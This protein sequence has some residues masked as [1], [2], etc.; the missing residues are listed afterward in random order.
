MEGITQFN[1]FT[2]VGKKRKGLD[3]KIR[4]RLIHRIFDALG[5][6][7]PLFRGLHL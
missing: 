4:T 6:P 1:N 7:D 5:L 2:E 3:E